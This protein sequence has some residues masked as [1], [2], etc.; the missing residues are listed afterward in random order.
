MVY[1]LSFLG[2]VWGVRVVVLVLEVFCENK[3]I[4]KTNKGI[5]WLEGLLLGTSVEGFRQPGW[6]GIPKVYLIL[7]EPLDGLELRDHKKG[8]LRIV[9][10]REVCG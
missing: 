5:V 9:R 2:G 8:M 3:F 6:M 10:G 1:Y 7:G 4:V